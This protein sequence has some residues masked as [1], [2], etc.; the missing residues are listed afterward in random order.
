MINPYTQKL[1]QNMYEIHIF[2]Y[3]EL[4]KKNAARDEL[5]R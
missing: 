2:R 1:E 3:R 4:D 5:D